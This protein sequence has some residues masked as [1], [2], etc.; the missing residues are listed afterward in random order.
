MIL[1]N[2]ELKSYIDDKF[3]DLDKLLKLRDDL[4]ER[5][6]VKAEDAMKIRLEGMNEFRSQLTEQAMTFL[7]RKEFDVHLKKIESNS[8][9]IY[10]GIGILTVLQIVWK[11]L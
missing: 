11:L 7:S 5:A 9:L 8:K 2:D 6:L 4:T 1:T 10:I 3:D